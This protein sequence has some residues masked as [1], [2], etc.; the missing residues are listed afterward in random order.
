MANPIPGTSIPQGSLIAP[1]GAQGVQGIQGPQG[2]NA[3]STDTGNIATIGSDSKILVPQSSIWS[4]RL[5]SF[6]AI[7]NPTFECDQRNVGNAITAPT[8]ANGF[9]V[10][11]WSPQKNGMASAAFQI[12][13]ISSGG[14]LVPGTSFNISASK[15]RVTLTAAQASLAASDIFWLTQYV[16]GPRMRE[17][18][19]DVHSFSVLAQSTVANLSFALS[20]RDSGTT[21]SLCKLCTLGAANTPTLIRL[22]NLPLWVSGGSWSW[23]PGQVGYILSVALCCG[24]TYMP[25]ANDTWQN[26]NFVGAVG[27]SN[28][29]ASP[30]NSTLD[31]LFIQHEPGAL[32][33]TPMDC[34]FETN[35]QACLRY[36]GKSWD[37]GTAIG[38]ASD[39]GVCAAVYTP[40]SQFLP[41]NVRFPVPMAKDVT[42]VF[43]SRDGATSSAV[44]FVGAGVKAI[45]GTATAGQ[46]GMPYVTF[47]AAP[48]ASADWAMFHYT[49]DTGW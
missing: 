17:L 13:Q 33:T 24:S 6:N 4:M 23:S 16:E 19:T 14:T 39:S 34:P 12:Q 8:A 46:K 21:H 43:Y 40:N 3:V 18:G 22:P 2:P 30:L 48:S 29:A 27:M 10:D 7:G 37:L 41:V 1:G 44:S 36:Y 15:L 20:L 42:P 11:R 45:N 31:L 5:R 9:A 49:I 47:G 32:C 35:Y 38:T 28:F 26:G 25:P